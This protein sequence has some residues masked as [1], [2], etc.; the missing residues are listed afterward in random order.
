M[1]LE[2]QS[3]SWRPNSARKEPDPLELPSASAGDRQLQ[4][5]PFGHAHPEKQHGSKMRMPGSPLANV[6]C[7]CITGRRKAI[8]STVESHRTTCPSGAMTFR[9]ERIR[10]PVEMLHFVFYPVSPF[11][12]YYNCLKGQHLLRCLRQP[13]RGCSVIADFR[14]G[15][16][17]VYRKQKFSVHPGPHAES[18]C[19]APN[20]DSYSY[21][22]Q[23]FWRVISV[24][25]GDRVVVC[26]RRGKQLAVAADD[27]ALRRATWWQRL[28]LRHRFPTLMAAE[29]SRLASGT[30][31]NQASP[32]SP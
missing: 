31:P 25:P 27:P 15:D 19:P 4:P 9:E 13:E 1:E 6:A 7:V 14:P 20:G 28:L 23:K 10:V 3:E 17:V 8:H 2:K 16:Y 5:K 22:V 32:N 30:L 12:V 26:T 21:C 29:E 24:E 18:I 11:P